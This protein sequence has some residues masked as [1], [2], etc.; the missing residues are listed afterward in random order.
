MLSSQQ[1]SFFVYLII[2]LSVFSCNLNL[3]PEPMKYKSIS[4]SEK[5]HGGFFLPPPLNKNDSINSLKTW[6]E[7]VGTLDNSFSTQTICVFR[8][9][10]NSNKYYTIYLAIAKQ[11]SES[12]R[13]EFEYINSIGNSF[14]IPD[15]SS[16]IN[17]SEEIIQKISSEFIDFSKKNSKAINNFKKVKL[18]TLSSDNYHFTDLLPK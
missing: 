4:S 3:K 1:N 2:L 17:T 5:I 8:L 10:I 14:E 18:V 15:G 6:F 11:Y 13:N 12:N 7:N 9:F 16:T